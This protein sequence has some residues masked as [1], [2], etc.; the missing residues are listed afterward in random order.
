[1]GA[2]FVTGGGLAQLVEHLGQVVGAALNVGPAGSSGLARCSNGSPATL[3]ASCRAAPF[4]YVSITFDRHCLAR[5]ERRRAARAIKAIRAT[6]ASTAMAT[7][8]HS[9]DA[10]ELLTGAGEPLPGRAVGT[11]LPG[12][13]VADD[14]G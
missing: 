4:A 5:A 6:A 11:G 7:H 8:S 9:R 14:G 3:I 1:M 2:F 10:A 13:A 12:W